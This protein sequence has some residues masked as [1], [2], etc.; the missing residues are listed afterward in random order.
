MTIAS[1]FSLWAGLSGGLLIGL[2]AAMLILL[3]GNIAGISGIV[4][5]LLKKWDPSAP[6]RLCFLFG[7]L[8][9]GVLYTAW[10]GAPLPVTLNTPAALTITAGLLVG[11][12]ARLGSGCTSGHGVCGLARLSPRSIA[13]T[14]TFMAMAML[15]VFVMR[16]VLSA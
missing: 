15:T 4:G 9:G 16:H 13:A 3:N 11:F 10:Q 8:G 5:S 14:L 2:S 6:W 7:M 1:D 12:G